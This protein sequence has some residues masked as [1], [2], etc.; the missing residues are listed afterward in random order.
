ML[1]TDKKHAVFLLA[2]QTEHSLHDWHAILALTA[3]VNSTNP[4]ELRY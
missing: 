3:D 2:D 4:D 1:I